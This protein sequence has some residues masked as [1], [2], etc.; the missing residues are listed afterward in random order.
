MSTEKSIIKADVVI[1]WT[2]LIVLSIFCLV[3]IIG[4]RDES[5]QRI[6]YLSTAP[7]ID[8]QEDSSL[9]KMFYYWKDPIYKYDSTIIKVNY[10]KADAAYYAELIQKLQKNKDEKA[11][12]KFKLN[13]KN[14]FS[15]ITNMFQILENVNQRI[16]IF[17]FEDD[18]LYIL[19]PDFAS[20]KIRMI[21]GQL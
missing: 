3:K 21:E 18:Y 13:N 12:I 7:K 19:K 10:N 5:F 15:D 20:E 1:R 9:Y 11:G 8:Q 6:Y 4:E 2:I 17:S 14:T 16:F